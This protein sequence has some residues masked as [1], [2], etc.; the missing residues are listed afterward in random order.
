MGK[1]TLKTFSYYAVLIFLLMIHGKGIE[2]EDTN[3]YM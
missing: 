1:L 2:L 3:K